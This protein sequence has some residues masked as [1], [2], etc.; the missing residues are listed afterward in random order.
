MLNL[1]NKRCIISRFGDRFRDQ[2]NL[3]SLFSVLLIV[4]SRAQPIV[5]V[6]GTCQR[7]CPYGVGDCAAPHIIKKAADKWC[8]RIR[9]CVAAE[10]GHFVMLLMS[11]VVIFTGFCSVGTVLSLPLAERM[12]AI[13][14]CLVFNVCR[15]HTKQ[16]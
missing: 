15:N 1:A 7:T 8:K 6:G 5:R 3:I 13:T 2:Y 14:Q 4:P 10:G 11:D 12:P 16:V 9:F